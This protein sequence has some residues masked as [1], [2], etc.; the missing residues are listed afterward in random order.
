MGKHKRSDKL[1][2]EQRKEIALL[3]NSGISRKLL[4]KDYKV[5]IHT[6]QAISKQIRRWIEEEKITTNKEQGFQYA[7]TIYPQ[8]NPRPRKYIFNFVYEPLI[9]D[10]QKYLIGESQERLF[11]KAVL[12]PKSLP[13]I[14]KK[15]LAKYRARIRRRAWVLIHDGVKKGVIYDNLQQAVVDMGYL[16][17][18]LEEANLGPRDRKIRDSLRKGINQVLK[19]L[20]SRERRIVKLRC[21]I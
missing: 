3:V 21:G 2:Q 1:T 19:T 4:A 11:F 6:I 5:S 13:N 14:D 20:T 15:A 8:L 17:V 9:R 7:Q 16:I 12:G 18:K 10:I